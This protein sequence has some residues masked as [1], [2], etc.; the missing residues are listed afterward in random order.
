MGQIHP[1]GTREWLE[2]NRDKLVKAANT[3]TRLMDEAGLFPVAQERLRKA[4]KFAT[5]DGGMKY[6]VKVEKQLQAKDTDRFHQDHAAEILAAVGVKLEDLK[7][8]GVQ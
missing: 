1:K 3:L 2:F 8:E 7:T 4:F 6:G 5:N